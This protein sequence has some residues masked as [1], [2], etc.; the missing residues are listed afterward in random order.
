MKLEPGQVPDSTIDAVQRSLGGRLPVQGG[1]DPRLDSILGLDLD[2]RGVDAF[3]P[4]NDG[5]ISLP[6]YVYSLGVDAAAREDPL[7]AAERTMIRFLVSDGFRFAASAEIPIEAMGD[8][9][10]TPDVS[11]GPSAQ[12]M[13]DLVTQ[14]EGANLPGGSFEVRLL[15]VPAIQVAALWLHESGNDDNDLFWLLGERNAGQS[16]PA[17]SLDRDSMTFQLHELA[18][19]WAEQYRSTNSPDDDPSFLGG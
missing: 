8:H 1:R 16:G 5:W 17:D 18:R 12:E 2:R 15:R 6:H 9:E 13:A 10:Q 3:P 7:A 11:S 19:E 4:P 14:V